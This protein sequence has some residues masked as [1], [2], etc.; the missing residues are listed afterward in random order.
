METVCIKLEY[1]VKCAKCYAKSQRRG[2]HRLEHAP[3]GSEQ[4]S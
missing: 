3:L 4:S 2:E 1:K